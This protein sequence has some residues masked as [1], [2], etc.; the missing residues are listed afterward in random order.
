MPQGSKITNMNAA[1]MGPQGEP[2]QAQGGLPA[3]DLSA[4]LSP[5]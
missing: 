4:L 1:R 3:D 5:H 2:N